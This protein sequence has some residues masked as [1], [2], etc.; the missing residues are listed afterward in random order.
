M[1]VF[2]MENHSIL[3]NFG[4]SARAAIPRPPINNQIANNVAVENYGAFAGLHRAARAAA[5]GL[6]SVLDPSFTFL[7][8]NPNQT[9]RA[10]AFARF[11]IGIALGQVAMTHDSGAAVSEK[12][13]PSSNAPIPLVGY[14]S[15]MRYSLT[16]LDSAI[17]GAGGM[18]TLAI[19]QSW[20]RTSADVTPVQFIALIRGW[21]ARLRSGVVRFPADAAAVNWTVVR[22]DALAFLAQWPND[23][24]Q[25]IDASINWSIAWFPQH[26][27]SNSVNWHMM[28]GYMI[29]MAASQADYEAWLQTDPTLRTPYPIV[30]P[31][32]R[33]PD[34]GAFCP[35]ANC[36][37][38]QQCVSGSVTGTSCTGYSTTPGGFQYWENRATGNDWTGD[39][40][41]TSQ[42][43]GLRFRTIAL[44]TNNIGPYPSMTSAEMRLLAAE[45]EYM[46]GNYTQAATYVDITRTGRGQLPG[47]VANGVT[48]TTTLVPG[49]TS[50]VPRIPV[51]P[52]YTTTACGNLWEAL[53]WEK[54]MET[55]YTRWGGWYLDGRR[56][57]DLPEGTAI[58]WPVPYQELQTR[59]ATN[60]YSTGGSG[61]PDGT[62]KG[63]YG[64]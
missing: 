35:G 51:G 20:M 28:W 43:R 27:Q 4:S 9:A 59:S 25:N 34:G 11:V 3:N 16:Y 50:C 18:G 12:D 26:Y 47:L 62:P 40:S 33:F 1:Y 32:R 61:A 37:L 15:L 54:R 38:A 36:R 6:N 57:G 42:Y 21:R 31:D 41:G 55:A 56:W 23:F 46:L 7:P 52:S 29:G 53:K 58:H 10:K 24:I 17:A 8:A 14:D 2:G 30:T 64:I 13:D 22:D 44:A 63:T 60:F 19:P 5:L 49:G 45:G 39:P 48:N